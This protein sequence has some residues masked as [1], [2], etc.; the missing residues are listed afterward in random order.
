MNI[1]YN[2]INIGVW[3][4]HGLFT[5]INKFK[6]CKLKDPEFEKRVN[7][8]D[9]LCLQEIQCGPT[10]TQSLAVEG[11]HLMSFHRKM[12]KN[13]RYFGSSMILIKNELKNGIKIVGNLSGDKIWVKLE[14]KFFGFEKD[15]FICFV[16][17]P[18]LSSVY[19]KSLDYDI[20]QKLEEDISNFSNHGNIILAGD[21]NAKTHTANDFVSDNK[22]NHSPVND[23]TV[24]NFDEPLVRKNLERHAVAV[25]PYS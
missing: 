4:I 2:F 15:I 9:I 3:N 13:K 7:T 14:N 19:T 5:M 6:C 22:D 17:A 8:F 16:Y 25:D 24:Y 18:P 20:F 10:D 11:F 21:M 1:P 12:S 23:I